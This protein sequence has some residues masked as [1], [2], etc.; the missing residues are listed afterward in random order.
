MTATIGA[1]GPAAEAI[2]RH[3]PVLVEQ[4]VASRITNGDA[5][6]WGAAAEEEARS[7]SAGRRSPTAHRVG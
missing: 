5:T 4:F 6:L 3:V 1:R 2:A 7:A